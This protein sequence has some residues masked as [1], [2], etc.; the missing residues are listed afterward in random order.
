[1]RAAALIL[2][3]GLGACQSFAGTPDVSAASLEAFWLSPQQWLHP[4]P[5]PHRHYP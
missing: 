3:V 2:C 1:M 4:H 5:H